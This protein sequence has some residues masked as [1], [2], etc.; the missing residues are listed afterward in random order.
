MQI[1]IQGKRV[2]YDDQAYA[3]DYRVVTGD[4]EL[5]RKART[6][7]GNL[8]LLKLNPAL[9][10]PWTNPV[11][12]RFISH[13]IVRL[14]L[15]WLLLGCL[16]SSLLGEGL[17]VIIGFAQVVFWV[18]AIVNLI[19]NASYKIAKLTSAFLLLN[20]AVIL[21]WFYWLMDKKNIWKN[22]PIKSS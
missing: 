15:P 14:F 17:L 10:F 7:Y 8:Q 5:R 20:V 4:T 3:Y 1:I 13:K 9:F 16:I 22:T 18:F 12:F 21:A 6:L 19:T 2:I 11:W